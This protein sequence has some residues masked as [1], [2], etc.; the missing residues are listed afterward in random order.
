MVYLGFLPTSIISRL[1]CYALVAWGIV[2]IGLFYYELRILSQSV[3]QR[4]KSLPNI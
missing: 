4:L 2:L 3:S 1:I